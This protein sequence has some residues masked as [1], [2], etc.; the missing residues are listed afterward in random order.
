MTAIE[1]AALRAFLESFG[2]DP[3]HWESLVQDCSVWYSLIRSGATAVSGAA[4]SQL[5]GSRRAVRPQ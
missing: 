2:I 1:Q 5:K 4:F 3:E